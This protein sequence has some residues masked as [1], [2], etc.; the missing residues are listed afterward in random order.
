MKLYHLYLLP[1]A[2]CGVALML[3]GCDQQPTADQIQNQRQEAV[4]KQA[5]MSVGLPTIQNFQEKR[6]LKQ[7]FEQRDQAISTVTYLTDFNAHLHKLCDS[8]GYTI[9]GGTQFTNPQHLEQAYS[10]SG[11]YPMPQAD[12]NGLYSPASADGSYIICKNPANPTETGA[13]YSE[14]KLITSPF[15][16]DVK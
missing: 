10:G 8:I 2:I 14:P 3:A 9:P 15:P 1:S 7:I 5:V 4:N 12:P 6:V 16:L 11:Y 13:V